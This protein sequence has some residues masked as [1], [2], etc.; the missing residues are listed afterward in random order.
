MRYRLFHI[1]PMNTLLR[2]G[3]VLGCLSCVGPASSKDTAVPNTA[4]AANETAIIPAPGGPRQVSTQVIL[5]TTAG[6]SELPI[7]N[8]SIDVLPG[9]NLTFS[10]RSGLGLTIQSVTW[11]RNGARL[12][13]PG[14]VLEVTAARREDSGY[15]TAA[16]TTFPASSL[17]AEQVLVRVEENRRQRMV[18]LSTRAKIS[19][20]Q[21]F[22][23]TG[24][25]VSSSAGST[26]EKK[27]LLVR[28]VGPRLANFGVLEPLAD[29]VVQ[30]FAADGSRVEDPVYPA[31]YPRPVDYA[32]ARVGAFPL[33]LGTRDVAILYQLPEGVF[34]A[35]VSSASG[36][37]GN[38]LLEI[39]DV[40]DDYYLSPLPGS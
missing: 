38:V 4:A 37:T 18:N 2:I 23:I 39:Y 1:F 25:V 33:P 24:F 36:G 3:C 11:Y 9:T 32:T 28:A 40:P 27:F 17:H 16:I 15:Y 30:V 5:A 35:R 7:P 21:P 20:T 26:R 31:V 12:N 6:I 34:S 19:A 22:F 14:P 29:P 13:A 10:V 8:A